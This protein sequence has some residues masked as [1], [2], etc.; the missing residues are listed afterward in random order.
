MDHQRIWDHFQ[1]R[2]LHS[3]SHAAGRY[4]A[5]IAEA[6]QCVG[7]FGSALNIGI[8]PGVIE[9]TLHDSNWRVAA[10]DP[11]EAAVQMLREHGIDARV[12][13][14]QSMS[15]GSA[16]FDIVIASEVLEHIEPDVREDVYGEVRRVLRPGGWLIGSVPYREDLRDAEV[17][18]PDCGRVFHR[19]GHVSRFDLED[20]RRELSAHFSAIK[21][22]RTAFVDWSEV[23]TP[24]GFARAITKYLLG[25]MGEAIVSPS[26][27]F[28]AQS[29]PNV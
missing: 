3:F 26:I 21:L 29:L 15:F 1:T 20:L 19:W 6:Q 4:R 27:R 11:S 10:L 5:M 2:G 28:V 23:R 25:R 8:G 17:A 13:W 9:R 12:G 18:C 16:E 7:A 22:Q 24:G 14:A